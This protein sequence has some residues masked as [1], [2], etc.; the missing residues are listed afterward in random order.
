M[1]DGRWVEF[2]GKRYGVPDGQ[3]ALDAMLRGGANLFFSCRKGS[4]RSCMLEAVSG[5]PGEAAFARLPDELRNL[6]FFLPCVTTAPDQVVARAPDLSRWVMRV[7]LAGRTWLADG[8]LRILLEPEQVLDWRP[9]QYISL[10]TPAGAARSYSIVSHPSDYYI[11]LHIRIYPEG[12][13]SPWLAEELEIG[14]M[15]DFTGPVGSCYYSDDLADLPLV[16]L[17]TGTGAGAILGIAR[18]ALRRNPAHE[19]ALYHGSTTEAGLYLRDEFA[20]LAEAHPNV[21]ATCLAS[22]E[23]ANTRASDQM[24]SDHADLQN[25]ALFLCGNADMVEAARIGGV[26]R[27]VVLSRIFADPFE[28][29]TPYAP[30]DIAKIAAFPPSPEMWAA[31]EEGAM[32]TRILTDFYDRVFE[33]PRLAPFFY[34]VTKQRLIEKQFAFTRDLL[35]GQSD[36]FGERPFNSH[37]WMIIS[38]ALFDYREQVFF[39]VVR[40]H[41][42]PERFVRI[43]AGLNERF[44]RE[45]VKST[46]RGQIMDGVEHFRNAKTRE[47]ITVDTLCDGCSREITTG[48]TVLLL[49]RTGEVFCAA[50]SA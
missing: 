25:K 26:E 32:L 19:I 28:P 9:G 42:L 21:R 37:H 33:D 41:G 10:R 49:Q 11:E 40:A 16:M 36:Y 22:Q 31:L 43:W 23:G 17:A 6:G 18:E 27:G 1:S 45:I 34:K 8:V 4:C 38:D 3:T 2:E 14:D 46:E 29:P 20:A 47:V 39:E 48:E 15:L 5:D 7:G 50:C 30:Q 24:L 44:R 12:A 13:V 35:L